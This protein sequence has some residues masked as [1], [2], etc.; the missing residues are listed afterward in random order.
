MIVCTS[1]SPSHVNNDTQ[2]KAIKSWQDLG[3]IVNS[4]NHPS[5][6]EAL[7]PLYKGVTF[8]PTERTLQATYGKPYVAI[9]AVLDWIKSQ[10]QTHYCLINS[11]I[12]LKTDQETILRIRD[13]MKT[14][15]VLANRVNYQTD[16][17]GKDYLS[18]IDVFFIHKQYVNMYPQSMY[19]F[20]QCFWDYEI[21]YVASKNS[22]D[23]FFIKQQ[24]AFHK[25][26][27]A[28]YNNDNW[29]KAGRFFL[30]QNGLYQ[31][32]DTT[33]INRMSHYVYNYIYN[34]AKRIE[35]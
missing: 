32:N 22:V 8:I 19:C 33:E 7:K 14:S 29:K 21:P 2:L 31:F 17:T 4:F 6:I 35:I 34:Y 20:G 24:I 3:L 30:W 5:E 16:Y 9:S 13:K 10:T 11:D 28:Q 25:D 26:H 15:I 12:E 18:G 27:K 1:I 23:V